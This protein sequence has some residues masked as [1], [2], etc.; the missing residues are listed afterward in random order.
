M[1][2]SRPVPPSSPPAPVAWVTGAAGFLGRHV[3]RDWA[4]RGWRVIAFARRPPPAEATPP[5]GAE[6]LTGEFGRAPL[7]R[8]AD[9]FGPPRVVFHGVG[10]GSVGAA[11]AD[12]VADFERTVGSLA[13]LVDV[14][15]RRAPGARLIYPSSAAVYGVTPP[16]P[17]AEDAP[18]APASSYGLHKLLA[19][20]LCLNARRIHGLDPV[21]VRC[22]SVYGPGQRKLLPWDLGRRLLAQDG[23][24][25]LAGTGA[26]VRDFI[27]AEDAAA[28][29]GLLA[30]QTASPPVVNIGSGA[31][32]TVRELAEGLAAALGLATPIGFTGAVR[33]GDPPWYQ[34]DMSRLA[35][36]GFR[37]RVGLTDGL[38]ALAGW[39]RGL[40]AD[41]R[42]R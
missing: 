8:A 27:A 20:T 17:V 22:F 4:A 42:A 26:E 40:P 28:A 18:P 9:R 14:L 25:T 30:D 6:L 39:L 10:S 29:I 1:P 12:P 7:E 37:P 34:A 31:A 2:A 38:A 24:V 3:V 23:P 21:V 13:L 32:T 5:A 33:A 16:G 41:E 36:L 15:A 11:L 19:E 35:G